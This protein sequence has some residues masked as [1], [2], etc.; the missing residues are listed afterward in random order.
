MVEFVLLL[1]V[2]FTSYDILLSTLLVVL[3]YN[4]YMIFI[5]VCVL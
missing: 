2:V 3:L 1:E 4:F 5:M